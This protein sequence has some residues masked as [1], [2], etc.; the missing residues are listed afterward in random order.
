MK[1]FLSANN[2]SFTERNVADDPQALNEL[3]EKSGKRATPVITVDEEVVVG[4]DFGR[5]KSLLGI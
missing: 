3:V 2:V 5:L 1:E 4:F